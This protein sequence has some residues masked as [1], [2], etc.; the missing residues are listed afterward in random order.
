[1]NNMARKGYLYNSILIMLGLL[2]MNAACSPISATPVPIRHPAITLKKCQLS[3]PG[4]AS[5][6]E[7]RCGKL[8]VYED[9]SASTSRQIELNLAVIPAIS[10]NP[11]PDPLFFIPGGPGEAATQSILTIFSAFNRINQKR[12]IV[13]VD[14]RGTGGSHPLQC[15]TSDE[16][17]FSTQNEEENL[18]ASLQACLNKL[19][20]DPRFYT[21]SIAMDD[22]DQARDAL[23]YDRINLYGASYGTRAA[24]TYL[25]QY[26]DHVRTVILDGVAPP[27]WTLGPS[28]ASDGQRALDMIFAR[29]AIEE[30]CQSSFPDLAIKF[31]SIVQELQQKPIEVALDDP[32]NGQP[33]TF[34]LTPENFAT[35]IH[36]MTYTPETAALIPL[37]I[38]N[39]NLIHDFR[40]IV[41]E[42]LSST[43]L[44]SESI[45][46][47][48]RYSIICSEDTP[49]YDKEP[50]SQGYLGIYI[51]KSFEDI[52]QIWPHGSIPIN[53]K[54]PVLSDKPVLILSGEAD[55]VTP[56]ANGNLAAQT[57]SNNLHLIIS[58]MG[59]VNIFRG[60]IPR[61]ATD[62]IDTGSL[63]GL[64]TTCVQNI[65]PLP[66]FI[67]YNGPQP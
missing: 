21:T 19:D 14:Q 32:I 44:F 25:R 67:N 8:K 57:L 2:A 55:P 65:K 29:C 48:M 6:L 35:T 50:A 63:Q 60:C 15:Q 54:Q 47:G 26:P 27:N 1:M 10:R 3:A 51:V 40:P 5:H 16:E 61:I 24:L 13:L 41:A 66:F 58:G 49:F 9:R 59:H 52:C 43:E 46:A 33:T 31:Q 42:S 23:G 22:L 28:T 62:F 38:H 37:M 36:T 17:V 20:A 53:F 11:A 30:K 45:S 34:K 12:D 39:A 4:S 18:A 7:A 56:P 64:D